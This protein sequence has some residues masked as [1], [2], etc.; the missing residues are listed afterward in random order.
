MEKT[1]TN[2]PTEKEELA[3]E[4]LTIH[5]AALMQYCID[6]GFD[7]EEAAIALSVSLLRICEENLE[8]VNLVIA[9]VWL[10]IN[11]PESPRDVQ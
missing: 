8:L 5:P 10:T 4:L 6:E 1:D 11:T 9:R 3:R 7:Q 2:D